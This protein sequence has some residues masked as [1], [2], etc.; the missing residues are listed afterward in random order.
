MAANETAEPILLE[1]RR[2]AVVEITL[3]RPKVLNALSFALLRALADALGRAAADEGVRAVI[4]T[5]AG[6]AFAAG[7]DIQ[8]LADM[9]AAGFIASD[10]FRAWDEVAAFP[11]PLIAA[12]NGYALGGGC[13]LAMSCDIIVASQ[14]ARFGQPEIFLGLIP[15]AGGT[16]R[17]PRAVGKYLASE[18]V[19]TGRQLTAAEGERFGLVNRVVPPALVM[20]A[21]R[22]IAD[23][24]AAQSPLAVR[25][26][27]AAL[28]AVYETPLAQGLEL[29]RQRFYALFGSEDQ[30][31][32]TRA[33]LEKRAAVWK[34]R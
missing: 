1:D 17:L 12:V 11:K 25:Q 19:L 18:L 6:R 28:R 31:E 15:G 4:L 21:A 26:A 16:Q 10:V 5:G 23:R 2:G 9:T 32:G 27:K 33:F 13:E 29:E 34:G 22:E 3:N 8:E 20:D 7:A 24:I 14:E 30:R